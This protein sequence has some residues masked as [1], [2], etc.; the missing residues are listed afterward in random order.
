MIVLTCTLLQYF[1]AS[2]DVQDSKTNLDNQID[3]KIS[4]INS[5]NDEVDSLNNE[6]ESLNKASS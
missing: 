6:V 4:E 1:L 5:L 2:H 3:D